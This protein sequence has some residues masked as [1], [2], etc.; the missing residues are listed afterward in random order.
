M[1]IGLVTM[2]HPFS[3][4]LGFQE[5]KM[6]DMSQLGVERCSQYRS[7]RI[8]LSFKFFTY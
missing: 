7:C 1:Y 4:M 2:I 5:I 8:V 3:P 6:R